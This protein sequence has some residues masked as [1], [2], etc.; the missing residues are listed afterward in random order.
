MSGGGPQ[1]CRLTK[2]GPDNTRRPEVYREL[3]AQDAQESHFVEWV[4]DPDREVNLANR[5][6]DQRLDSPK[7]GQR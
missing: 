3:A 2:V 4:E 1:G 5:A 6:N 7:V